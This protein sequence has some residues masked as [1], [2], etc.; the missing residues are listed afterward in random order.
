MTAGAR[1]LDIA[2]AA[3]A[4]RDAAQM[5]NAAADQIVIE[6]NHNGFA[7]LT[8]NLIALCGAVESLTVRVTGSMPDRERLDVSA[9]LHRASLS[10]ASAA[11]I[12]R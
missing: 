6:A 12:I 1:D 9:R 11:L 7:H 10:L 4:L 8:A 5:M 2:A 3:I